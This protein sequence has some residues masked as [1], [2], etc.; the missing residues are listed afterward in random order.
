[1]WL[2]NT[3][4]SDKLPVLVWKNGDGLYAGFAADNTIFLA[5]HALANKMGNLS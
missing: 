3:T 2:A 1:V 4:S 5:S